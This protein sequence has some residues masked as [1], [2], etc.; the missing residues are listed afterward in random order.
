MQTAQAN[1]KHGSTLV[2]T[3]AVVATILVLL[4]GAVEYTTHISRVTQ[5]SRKTA[6]ALEIAD[7]HLETLFSNWRNI[8]RT[9]WTSTSSYYNGGAALS[10]VG[11]NYFRTVMY[12]PSPDPTP[13]P[14]MNPSATPPPIP[15][16]DRS[17]FPSETNYTVDQYR[18]QAVDPMISLD[19]NENAMVEGNANKKGSGNFVP[20]NP[21]L[22][23]PAS[24]G[25]N[26]WQYSLFYLAAVDISL[27]AL[28]GNVTAKVRRVFEKKFDQPWTYAVFY[29]DDLEYQPASPLTITGPIH[30]NGNLYIGTSNFTAKSNV[31]YGGDFVNGYAPSDPRYPGGSFSSPNFPSSPNHDKDIPPSQASPYL[32]F[33]WNLD[34]STA[35]TSGSNNNSYHEIIER[36]ASGADPLAGVRYYNQPSYRVIVNSAS[37][38]AS[39]DRVDTYGATQ[40]A[41]SNPFLSGSGSILKFG[42]AL[43][44]ARENS[45]VKVVDVDVARIVA[46]VGMTGW[47]GVLYLGDDGG[48]TYNKDGTIKKVGSAATV[49]IN[50]VSYS[51]T[52]RAFRLINGYALPSGGLTIV[53]ECPVYIQGNYNTSKYFGDSIPS[54]NGNYSTPTGSGYTRQAAAVVGDA[55]TILSNNWNDANS[56]TSN[57]NARPAI[58]T[59]INTALV[60]GNVPSSTSGGYSGGGESFFRLLEDWKSNS[61]CYYGSMVQLFASSQARAAWD[62]SGTAFKEP[63]TNHWF[64]DDAIFSTYSPPGRLEIAAYLQ[65]QRWYQV[66]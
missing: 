65:Q 17:L 7:G 51:T 6:Q 64:Y 24:Y 55:I 60:A 10:L 33:G 66:Y 62:A 59:T 39:V 49:T 45:A 37:T 31:E 36:P 56:A 50:G 2:V 14:Y 53:S 30:T 23:P 27:P 19:Q 42:K 61:I 3:V 34:I 11:T 5:R 26:S 57:S 1:T 47:T 4:S 21:G 43:Y 38:N 12:S 58:S 22:V 40:S 52:R 44:D 9:T 29:V 16:P 13:V 18:I 20:L 41:S 25:P 63:K 48:A 32:P 35:A 8:Y 46:N 28:T 54:N 15:L